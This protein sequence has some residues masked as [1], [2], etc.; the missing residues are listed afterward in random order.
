[1]VFSILFRV[2]IRKEVQE[3]ESLGCCPL[4]ALPPLPL[5]YFD[6]SI[7]S[8]ADSCDLLR[9]VSLAWICADAV[10]IGQDA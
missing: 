7:N 3:K 6:R 2:M 10:D 9:K 5:A 8:D 4:G 1:L